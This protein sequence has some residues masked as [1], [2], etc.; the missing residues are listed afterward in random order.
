MPPGGSARIQWV[1]VI[2]RAR[3]ELEELDQEQRFI[4]ETDLDE[5]WAQMIKNAEDV[6]HV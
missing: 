2:D 5:E 3:K 4:L 1:N 6:A